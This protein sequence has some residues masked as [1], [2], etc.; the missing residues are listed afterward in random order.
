MQPNKTKIALIIGAMYL[1]VSGASM[2]ATGTFDITVTTIADVTLEER[3]ILNFGTNIFTTA[4]T[5][6]MT[7]SG[8]S[9]TLMQV[10]VGTTV[11]ATTVATTYGALSGGGCVTGSN[12]GTPGLYRI[13]GATGT[14]VNITMSNATGTGW[15]FSPTSAFAANYNAGTAASDD[16][17]T[18]MTATTTNV[19]S[20][21]AAADGIDAVV[22]GQLVFAVGGL[23]TVSST[24]TASLAYNAPFVVSVVY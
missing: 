9:E 11:A 6:L 13:S 8:N 18:A 20:L 3:A 17:V 24:L 5:C 19:R 16:T 4:G 2:A 21:A 7:G 23:L 1:G 10:D 12:L 22:D 14:A 15:S